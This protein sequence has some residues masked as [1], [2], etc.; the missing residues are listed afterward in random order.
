MS[1]VSPNI[2]RGFLRPMDL[3]DSD[4][5][6]TESTVTFQSVR[7]SQPRASG[8]YKLVV[9]SS[10]DKPSSTPT[11]ITTDRSGTAGDANGATFLWKEEG[12]SNYGYDIGGAIS[13]F[14][15][16]EVI[17]S[18]GAVHQFS[19]PQA[20]TLSNG[21]SIVVYEGRDAA[22]KSRILKVARRNRESGNYAK[23][24]LLSTT[25]SMELYPTICE[26]PNGDLLIAFWNFLNVDECQISVLRSVD[27]GEN[28]T[29]ITEAALTSP[30]SMRASSP[31]GFTPKRLR[32][33]ANVEHVLMVAELLFN[34]TQAGTMSDRIGQFASSNMGASFSTVGLTSGSVAF[35]RYKPDCFV[36]REGFFRVAV[37]RTNEQAVIFKLPNA[38]FD[39]T[40]LDTTINAT[41]ITDTGNEPEIADVVTYGATFRLEGELSCWMDLEGTFYVALK[42]VESGVTYENSLFLRVSR[43]GGE[44]W[45][46]LNNSKNTLSPIPFYWIND[47]QSMPVQISGSSSEGRQLIVHTHVASPANFDNSI[48]ALYL[49]GYSKRTLH[50]YELV[51]KWYQHGTLPT[52]WIPF[53]KPQDT[54]IYTQNLAGTAS[55]SLGGLELTISTAS[56]GLSSLYYSV[57]PTTTT[58]QGLI[59]HTALRTVNGYATAAPI[60]QLRTTDTANT[61]HIK[62]SLTSTSLIVR[63]LNSSVDIITISIDTTKIFE[64]LICMR[65]S[66][67]SLYYQE[68]NA[69][70]NIKALKS[71]ESAFATMT[72]GGA[73]SL[74]PSQ[75]LWGHTPMSLTARES[76]WSWFNFAS[77]DLTGNGI[78]NETPIEGRLYP[79][80]GSN[81][82]LFDG[83]SISTRDGPGFSEEQYTI[84]QDSDYPFNRIFPAFSYSPRVQYRSAAVTSGAVS[85]LYIP[86]H[87]D[88]TVQNLAVSSLGGDLIGI[89][90]NGINFQNVELYYYNVGTT[91]WVQYESTI[92]LADGLSFTFSRTGSTVTAGSPT[93]DEIYLYHDE[94]K[95]WTLKMGSTYR[96]IVSNTEGLL[97][98]TT[99]K[100]AVLKLEGVDNAADPTS[101]TAHIIPSSATITA[102]LLGVEGSAWALKIPSQETIDNYFTIGS[103]LLGVVEIQAPQYGRGRSLTYETNT[104]IYE[105]PDLGLRTRKRSEGRRTLSVSWSSGVSMHDYYGSSLAPDYWT[106]S[107]LSGAE[108]VA[109]VND[110]AYQMEGLYRYLEGARIPTVYLPKIQRATTSALK[111]QVHNRREAHLY[112]YLDSPITYENVLGDEMDNEVLRIGSL[113]LK[114]I[115]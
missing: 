96:R 10:G 14:E 77:G 7:P 110:V 52:T 47:G 35:A 33:A 67:L 68:S 26:L 62:I 98:N 78:T 19:N 51:P 102:N 57:N 79:L 94:A 100:K 2:L 101:G 50:T 111:I 49:G 21:N 105:A 81:V 61:Y 55:D 89:H 31:F 75:I 24:T 11:I 30:I 80:S 87:V 64:L 76:K 4:L 113:T 48:S 93:V 36:D 92:D 28:W 37:I 73:G 103:F 42:N 44:T 39:I 20:L 91:S 18:I 29:Q 59:V 72:S 95:D 90:L 109:A 45:H 34:D 85:E 6:L 17:P 71:Y 53:D 16:I 56:G 115:I 38:Y 104:E 13:G 66:D 25:D 97:T 86:F 84:E 99:G 1:D 9:T 41:D 107:S 23:Q 88:Q 40:S 27:K 82:Y 70:G 15:P 32:I 69:N 106:A 46:Y 43:D 58:T 22:V 5:W 60:M 63:D 12:G 74:N 54:P 114:E 83:L 3:S 108:P 65:K 112:C 8:D